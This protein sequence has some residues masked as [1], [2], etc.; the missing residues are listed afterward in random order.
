[1][2]CKFSDAKVNEE[3]RTEFVTCDL[4]AK[5]TIVSTNMYS[6]RKGGVVTRNAE[7]RNTQSRVLK[8]KFSEHKYKQYYISAEKVG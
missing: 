8:S 6:T 5:P 1:M 3:F 4:F 7:N 2:A